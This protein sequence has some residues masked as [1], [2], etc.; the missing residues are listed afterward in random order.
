MNKCTVCAVVLTASLVVN[1]FLGW[2]TSAVFSGKL[3][4]A[5]YESA[6]PVTLIQK[7]QK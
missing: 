1:V 6:D 4:M 7:A 3:Q 5:C 2:F